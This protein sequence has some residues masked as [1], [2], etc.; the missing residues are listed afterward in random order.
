[1]IAGHFLA[2]GRGGELVVTSRALASAQRLEANLVSP[3]RAVKVTGR[4]LDAASLESCRQAVDGCALC[5]DAAGP[6]QARDGTLVRA[7]A[8]A[9]CDYLDLSDDVGYSG[10][11]AEAA[12]SAPIRV[13]TSHSTFSATVL[14]LVHYLAV[15]RDVPRQVRV[16][17]VMATRGGA[18]RAAMRTLLTTLGRSRADRAAGFALTFPHP[19]G[20]RELR[21]YPTPNERWLREVLEVPECASAIGFTNRAIGPMLALLSRLGLRLSAVAGPLRL[22]R[23]IMDAWPRSRMLGCLQISARWED[24]EE[25][26]SLLARD[27]A[28]DVPCFPAIL[29]GLAYL[30]RALPSTPSG[31]H[32]LHEWLPWSEWEQLCQ[33]GGVEMHITTGTEKGTARR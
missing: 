23:A 32:W 2:Q 4:A 20:R 28:T 6:F 5:I 8:E 16:G 31:L 7:C 15:S 13:F 9:G 3:E 29:T 18:G 27:D 30:R 1:L 24:R 19:L 12:A 22:G 10:R 14:F 26:V 25:T 33:A 17:L 11:V 21:I